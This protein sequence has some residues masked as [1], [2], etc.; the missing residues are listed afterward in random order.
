MAFFFFFRMV[1]IPVIYALNHCKWVTNVMGRIESCS[2]S[3]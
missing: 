1:L 2:A 3:K